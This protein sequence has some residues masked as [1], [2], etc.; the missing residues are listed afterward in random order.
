MPFAPS[1]LGGAGFTP[2]P[3]GFFLA[4]IPFPRNARYLFVSSLLVDTSTLKT[5]NP[6]T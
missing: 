1:Q 4:R 6:R 3:P 2:A 5:N